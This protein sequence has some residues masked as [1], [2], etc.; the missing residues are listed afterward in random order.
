MP[1]FTSLRRQYDL[2]LISRTLDRM[3]LEKIDECHIGS[4][5]SSLPFNRVPGKHL[6][7]HEIATDEVT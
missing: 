6:L 3:G 1:L 2:S 5:W 4:V 7:N